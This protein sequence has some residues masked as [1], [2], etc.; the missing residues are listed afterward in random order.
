MKKFKLL[1]I[2]LYAKKWYKR[3]DGDNTIWDDLRVI[4]DLDDYNGEFMSKN[5]MVMIMLNHC[6]LLDVRAF[7]D[8]NSFASGICRESSWRCGYR[9]DGMPFQRDDE[10]NLPEWDYHEAIIH[11]CLSNL[12]ITETVKLV[13][14]GGCLPMPNYDKGLKR[15]KGISNKNLKE[16]FGN[17]IERSI[18]QI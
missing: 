3:Y 17:Q 2:T 18:K 6:Q 1:H 5:D 15:R 10:Q 14:E 12:S 8:L 9:Y 11:Y 13:G 7:T 16:L 4:F